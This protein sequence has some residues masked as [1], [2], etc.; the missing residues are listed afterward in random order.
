MSVLRLV[1]VIGDDVVLDQDRALVGREPTCDVIVEHGSVSRKHAL[2]ERRPDGWFVVDQ[3]SANGTFID[4]VKVGESALRNGQELRF[5]AAAYRVDLLR[6]R[7]RPAPRSSPR[8][9]RDGADP[10]PAGLRRCAAPAAPAGAG[11]PCR[12]AA[13]RGRPPLRRA[14]RRHAAAA[15]APPPLRRGPPRRRRRRGSG[16]PRC[17]RW[18]RT[19]PARARGKGRSFW[20]ATGCGGCLLMVL[21]FVGLIAGGACFMTSGATD[22]VRGAARRHQVRPDRPGLRPLSEGY[23]AERLPRGFA[24]FVDRHPSLKD[25]ADATFTEPQRD[26]RPRAAEGTLKAGSGVTESAAYRLV[27]EGGDWKIEFMEVEG[28]RPEPGDVAQAVAAAPSAEP[29]PRAD[30]G[31]TRQPDQVRVLIRAEAAGFAVRPDAGPFV[32]DLAEDVRPRAGRPAHPGPDARRRPAPQGPHLAAARA[33]CTPSSVCSPSIRPSRPAPTSCASPS[34]TWSAADAPAASS[35]STCREAAASAP[36]AARGPAREGRAARVRDLGDGHVS[37][38]PLDYLRSWCPC[39]GCQGHA[40]GSA[41][42][43]AVGPGADAPGSRRQ[44]RDRLHLG[45]ATAPGS[46]ASAFCAR[47]CPCA[48]CGGSDG[49]DQ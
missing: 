34:A 1:P 40:P 24:A 4:S 25:N 47:L 45:T 8:A 26:Q 46:T 20:I 32:Y 49:S 35:A 15:P 29:Q 6:T 38:F 9:R 11:R 10:A 23:R 14:G 44:L 2:L 22:A 28:D 12:R 7:T 3:A 13:L 39:A 17:R 16:P 30:V 18:R 33:P 43:G 37:P 42:P 21:L 31:K 48:A 27:K 5:G 41:L 19:A 36:G